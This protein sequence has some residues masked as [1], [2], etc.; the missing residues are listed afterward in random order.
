MRATGAVVD[1]ETLAGANHAYD[2]RERSPL[3]LLAFDAGLRED[4][5]RI[6][7]AWLA[8]TAPPDR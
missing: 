7:A 4:A 2:Q 8:E 3:S 1:V 6:V 5:R